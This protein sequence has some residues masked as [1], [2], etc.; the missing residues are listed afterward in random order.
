MSDEGCAP[1]HPRSIGQRLLRLIC[2]GTSRAPGDLG[3]EGNRPL[4]RRGW[5]QLGI[6]DPRQ[7]GGSQNPL[8]AP[9]AEIGRLGLR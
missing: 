2:C 8:V 4:R 6:A 3:R 7:N 5:R 9:I 1:E